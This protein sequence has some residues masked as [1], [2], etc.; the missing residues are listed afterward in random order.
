MPLF[1]VVLQATPVHCLLLRQSLNSL[2]DNV[3]LFISCCNFFFR[4]LFPLNVQAGVFMGFSITSAVFGGIIIISYSVAIAIYSQEYNYRYGYRY[5]DRKYDAEMAITA[6]I[7][8]L[9][10]VE[11]AIGIWAAICCCMMKPCTCCYSTPPQQVSL[12]SMIKYSSI[13]KT[14]SIYDIYNFNIHI[15]ANG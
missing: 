3:K 6:I 8:L 11:F 10:I 13:H 1:V 2:V 4:F 9:G 15:C 5:R 12:L 7:L 14:V